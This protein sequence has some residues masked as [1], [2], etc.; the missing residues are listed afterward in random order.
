MRHS[1]AMIERETE[2]Q[3]KEALADKLIDDLKIRIS[4]V[5]VSCC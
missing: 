1:E 4:E 2:Y 5:E 3:Q